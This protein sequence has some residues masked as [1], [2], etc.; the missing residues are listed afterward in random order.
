MGNTKP[1]EIISTRF[2]I[3]R[4][5]AKYFLIRVQKSFRTE[6]PPHRLILEFIDGQDFESLPRPHQVA[7]LMKES[8]VWVH[9]LNPKPLT[10]VDEEDIYGE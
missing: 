4:E 3:S 6:K 10:P 7:V 5:S 8:G 2:Q 9:P 1:F